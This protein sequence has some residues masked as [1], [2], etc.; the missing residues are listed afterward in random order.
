[1]IYSILYL[2]A[3]CI[4][5]YGMISDTSGML[6]PFGLVYGTFSVLVCIMFGVANLSI[7]MNE[8][9]IENRR[10]VTFILTDNSLPFKAKILTRD[11]QGDFLVIKEG[12]PDCEYSISA[13]SVKERRY[14]RE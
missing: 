11:K 5:S 1:M 8:K 4:I 14:D 12:E 3:Q 6:G 2:I 7:Y 9:D 13:A 10:F